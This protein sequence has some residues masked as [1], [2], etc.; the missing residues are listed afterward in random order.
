MMSALYASRQHCIGCLSQCDK[1]RRRN[2]YTLDVKENSLL[3]DKIIY[4]ENW[5]GFTKKANRTNK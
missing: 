2:P 1:A 5:M 4:I 3:T